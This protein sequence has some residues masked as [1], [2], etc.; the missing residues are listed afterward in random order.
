LLPHV[1]VQVLKALAECRSYH[2][3]G[4]AAWVPLWCR[5]GAALVP[6][7]TAFAQPGK[8]QAC[9]EFGFH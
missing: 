8:L 7:A 1:R 2:S 4:L 9:S 3:A 5:F 6:I